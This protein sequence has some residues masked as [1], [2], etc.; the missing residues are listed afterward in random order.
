MNGTPAPPGTW[1]LQSIEKALSSL[2]FT[3]VLYFYERCTKNALISLL[4]M[5]FWYC[6]FIIC[7]R[8]DLSE[9]AG[10]PV[11]GSQSSH[12][13]RSLVL[14]LHAPPKAPGLS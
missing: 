11:C 1:S 14:P 9:P 5:F 12:L 2:Y 10:S 3:F 7:T 8:S 6:L 13:P 4:R